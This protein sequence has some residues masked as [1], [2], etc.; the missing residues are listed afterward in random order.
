MV[1]LW[2]GRNIQNE[3]TMMRSVKPSK[4]GEACG[5]AAMS[6]RGYIGCASGR[7]ELRPNARMTLTLILEN[8]EKFRVQSILDHHEPSRDHRTVSGDEPIRWRSAADA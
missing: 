2:T 5:Q 4:P 3:S 8:G 1:S 6:S 7:A